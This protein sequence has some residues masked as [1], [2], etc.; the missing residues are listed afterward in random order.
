MDGKSASL[1]KMVSDLVDQSNR[2]GGPDNI[3]ALV[4][5]CTEA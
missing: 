3:T 5:H 4:L 1:E 2:C